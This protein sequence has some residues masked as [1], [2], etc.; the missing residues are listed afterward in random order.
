MGGGANR[1]QASGCCKGALARISAVLPDELRAT[2]D[3]STLLVGPSAKLPTD[4][5]D[6][7]ILR[8]AIRAERKVLLDYQDGNGQVT[9]R[10]IWPFALSFLMMRACSLRG[11]NCVKASGTFARTE[12]LR[13]TLW[14]SVIRNAVRLC[15]VSG[16]RHKELN[17]ANYDTAKNWQCGA[18]DRGCHNFTEDI[19]MIDKN[20][21]L[22]FV[23]DTDASIRFYTKLLGQEPVAAS[24]TFGMF[25]LPSGLGLGLWKKL[26]LNWHQPPQA[27]G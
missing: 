27:G 4:G 12:L 2:L 20:S 3:T 23:T 5:I 11:A 6:T 9:K 26:A 18:V 19:L 10:V 14:N 21:I 17:H 25:I 7:A 22:L 8:E 24:P 15:C 13:L 1:P 16:V